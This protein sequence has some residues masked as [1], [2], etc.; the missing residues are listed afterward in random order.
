M[1]KLLLSLFLLAAPYWEAKAPADW[2]D[3]EVSQLL[4]DSPWAQMVAGPDTRGTIPPVQ[5]YLATAAPIRL[6]EVE[7]DRRAKL[8]ASATKAKDSGYDP[9]AEEYGVWLE[10]NSKS[11]IIVAIRVGNAA[12]Y[13]D[14]KELDSLEDSVMRAGGKK[15]QMTG[16]FPPSARDPY[17]R[18]A[19]P[20]QVQLSD[21][22]LRFE[23][24]LPGVAGPFRFAEFKLQPM[25]VA[26]KLEL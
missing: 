2:T 15:I 25:T 6:A 19:F 4:S 24:Y 16:Y 18:I 8:R 7:R 22:Q 26:G 23:L 20:R 3:A 13:S 1:P 14:A 21:K 17:L 10:D 12:A 11:H 5:V 9:F